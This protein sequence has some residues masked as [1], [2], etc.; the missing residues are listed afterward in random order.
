MKKEYDLKSMKRRPG[1]AK[2]Y[3]EAAK[4][5]TNIRL[6]AVVV[7]DLKDEAERMGIPYQ[8]LINSILHRFITGQ[9]VDK[10]SKKT[11]S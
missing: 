11:G 3:P 2:A 7:N 9:L 1:K 8:T 10:P 6:D 5:A 4:V